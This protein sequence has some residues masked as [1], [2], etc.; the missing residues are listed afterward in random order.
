MACDIGFFPDVTEL[1]RNE[2][3]L[4]EAQRIAHLGSW[5]WDLA[6]DTALRS[7]EL[8]RICGVEPGT[9]A[10]TTE[11]FLAFV[12]PDDRGRVEASARAATSIR[13]SSWRPA[14]VARR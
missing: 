5:E 13:P 12:H 7:E 8:H 14:T 2:R 1:R 11:A 6:T 10:G 3:N 9:I 4:A